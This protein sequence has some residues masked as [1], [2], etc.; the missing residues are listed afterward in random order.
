[1]VWTVRGL[2]SD[3]EDLCKLHEDDGTPNLL[4]LAWEIFEDYEFRES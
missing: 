3:G 4:F 2:G 1:M